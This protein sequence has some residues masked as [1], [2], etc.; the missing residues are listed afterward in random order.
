MQVT[1]TKS[2]GLIKEFKVAVPAADIEKNVNGRLAELSRTA[3]IPGFRPGHAPISL[4]RKKYGLSVMGEV[5]EK[6]VSESSAKVITDNDLKPALMPDIKVTSFEDGSDLEYTMAV[7]ILPD[8]DPGDMSKLKLTRMNVKVDEKDV[9]KTLGRMAESY[10]TSTPV[11]TG[12]RSKAGDVLVIDF[13]GRVEGEEFAGGKA[14]DYSL[15]LG[16]ASFI[17]GFEDQLTGCKAGDEKLVK[18]TFPESYGA[19]ELAGK[20]AEFEVTVKEI[21]ETAPSSIDD[22][23]ARKVGMESL[24]K[25]KE[26]ILGEH[27]REYR[28]IARQRLKRDLLDVLADEYDFEVPAGLVEREFERIW[29]QFEEHR[30]VH[31]HEEDEGKSDDE[32][33]E[34]YRAIG[35]RRVRLGLL[36]SEIGRRNNLEVSQ[37][38]VNKAIMAHARNYPGQEK[39]VM[40]HFH[41]SAEAIEQIRGPLVEDK[42]VDFIVEL[43]QVTDKSVSAEELMEEKEPHQQGKAKAKTRKKPKA[44]SET[45]AK[46]GSETKAKAKPKAKPKAKAKVKKK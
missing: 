11:T 19:D 17:P 45:K 4:L 26:S 25:L 37:E 39:A 10:K 21:K 9:E 32:I 27:G 15:E 1:E 13:V 7:E 34:E 43:A 16:S 29:K 44:G 33:K 3:N 38:E 14:E 24:E 23:L 31:P 2:K 18:V 35:E 28:E 41:G 22:G 42:V 8:I 30:K 46:A 5:L 12:R 36:L 20:D 6:T 40:D